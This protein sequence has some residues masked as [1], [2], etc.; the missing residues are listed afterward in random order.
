M[1]SRSRSSAIRD[2]TVDPTTVSRDLEESATPVSRLKV[3]EGHRP[4]GVTAQQAPCPSAHPAPSS[5]R[6]AERMGWAVARVLRGQP[7]PLGPQETVATTSSRPSET[8][9]LVSAVRCTVRYI[10]LPFVLPLLGLPP[11]PRSAS[12][13]RSAGCGGYNTPAAG[14]TCRWRWRYWSASFSGAT[15]ACCS[16]GRH[17]WT[18]LNAAL[19]ESVHPI[20]TSTRP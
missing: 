9:L 16:S 12:S 15:R 17:G 18:Y 3:D 13:P 4:G 1:T 5:S 2:T 8:A 7:R 6:V 14:S 11:A 10:V 20:R 19:D